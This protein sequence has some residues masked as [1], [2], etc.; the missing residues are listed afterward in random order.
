MIT[1]HIR[2]WSE[3]VK[4]IADVRKAYSVRVTES[5]DGQKYER[6]KSH[7]ILWTRKCKMEIANYS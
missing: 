5:D 1:K 2:S 7:F 4:A 6:K 3:F